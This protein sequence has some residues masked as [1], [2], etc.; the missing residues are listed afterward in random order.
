MYN[1]FAPENNSEMRM[2]ME[3][4]RVGN[5]LTIPISPVIHTALRAIFNGGRKNK[6]AS[7]MTGR[8][9]FKHETRAGYVVFFCEPPPDYGNRFHPSIALYYTPRLGFIHS[10]YLRKAVQDLSVET[11]D[12]FLILMSRIVALKEPAEGIAKIRLDEIC[13]LRG[14][15][16]RHGSSHHLHEDF[17]QEVIRLADLR[18]TMSWKDYKTGRTVTIGKERPDRLLDILDV[19]YRD[20][21]ERWISFRYRCGQSLSQF[22]NPQG[23]YWTGHYSTSLLQL[24]PYHDSFTKKVGT[25]WI[26]IGTIAMKKGSLPRA[27]PKTIL[28]F[29][30]E[31]IDLKHPGQTVDSFIKAHERL[32]DLGLIEGAPTLE[33]LMRNRGYFQDWLNTP[34]MIKLSETLWR[35]GNCKNKVRCWVVPCRQGNIGYSSLDL[36]W[37]TDGA[38]RWRKWVMCLA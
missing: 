35:T 10:G 29:C 5:T 2:N 4:E 28:D 37:R 3:A 9:F 21:G 25:Y 15:H 13:K 16:V 11:A 8:P 30:G 7:D 17:K 38:A 31:D 34:I 23:L 19:E 6:W 12:V 27:T 32:E 36:D 14:V 24:N 22:L 20:K 1:E 18:L 26:T 33:P